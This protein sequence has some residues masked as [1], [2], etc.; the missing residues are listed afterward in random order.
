MQARSASTKEVFLFCPKKDL[1]DCMR[2]SSSL[3]AEMVKL[4]CE[5]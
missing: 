4:A 2:T 3:N 1:P 5:L